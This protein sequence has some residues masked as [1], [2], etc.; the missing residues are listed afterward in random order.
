MA[1][2]VSKHCTKFCQYHRTNASPLRHNSWTTN[3]NGSWPAGGE[4]DIIEG[5]NTQDSNQITLHTGGQCTTAANPNTYRGSMTNDNCQVSSNP[6][7]CF[8]TDDNTA[9]Y[10]KSFNAGAGGYYAMEWTSEAISVWWWARRDVPA[11]VASGRPEP[12]SWA[13]PVAR[14]TG[15]DIDALFQNHQIVRWPS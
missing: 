1:C 13:T 6:A 8:V 5:V 11:D 3:L 12:K 15:C 9:S 2:I 10:G 4:I 7:G 14:F